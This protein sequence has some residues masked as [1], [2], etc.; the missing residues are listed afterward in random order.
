MWVEMDLSWIL[1]QPKWLEASFIPFSLWVGVVLRE[2]VLGSLVTSGN[3]QGRGISAGTV[4]GLW[5]RRAEC[6]LQLG[7]KYY[8][9][10]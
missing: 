2:V 10:K 8:E 3:I 1:S 5:L 7:S 6:T 4:Y 9:S